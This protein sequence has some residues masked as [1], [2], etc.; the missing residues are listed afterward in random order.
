MGF[1]GA[2]SLK[3]PGAWGPEWKHGALARAFWTAASGPSGRQATASAPAWHAP[4]RRVCRL[5]A[6]TEV[7][8][9]TAHKPRVA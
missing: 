8:S 1:S 4:V 6:G 3:G 7:F 2:E 5:S 9:V